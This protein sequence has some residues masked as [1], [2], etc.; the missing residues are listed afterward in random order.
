VGAGKRG[1]V[2]LG[3]SITYPNKIGTFCNL[4]RSRPM[5]SASE[6]IPNTVMK[7]IGPHVV[8]DAKR[9]LRWAIN[10]T[11]LALAWLTRRGGG[12][13]WDGSWVY[14]L[15]TELRIRSRQW[16]RMPHPPT[17]LS[18]ATLSRQT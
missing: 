3:L 15:A 10:F 4:I 17:P 11:R 8:G 18:G 16:P 13:I 1:C 12:N 5:F 2:Q 7:T 9:A 14:W 6:L